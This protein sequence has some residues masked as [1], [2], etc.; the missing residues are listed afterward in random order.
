MD[1]KLLGIYLQDHHAGS[2]AGLELARR[3]RGANQGTTYGDFL[4]GLTD[5][6]EA[7]RRALEGIMDDLGVSRDRAKVTLAWAGEKVGRLKPNGQL[8]GYS[9]LSRLIEL[10]GLALGVTGKLALWRAL[11]LVAEDEPNL[12]A[13][14]VERLAERAK[15]Q[16]RGIE[17]HRL[18]ATRQAFG[19]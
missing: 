9:P 4:S 10:E 19:S 15:E 16:Q 7:D 13:A 3:A 8:T 12:D 5:E 17:G 2:T 1:R 11:S 14:Y 6:I 18:Q